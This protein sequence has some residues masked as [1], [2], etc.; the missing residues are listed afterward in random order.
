MPIKQ[1]SVEELKAKM[2][3]GEKF[4]LVD[5]RGH[6]EYE[7]AQ[8]KGS[9]LIPLQEFPARAPDELSADDEIVIHCHHGGRSQRACQFLADMGYKNLSNLAGGIDAWSVKIDPQV[10]R[11]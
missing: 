7:T 9:V 5:V 2:D 11:Y 3:R 8:I 10:K 4:K 1:I 6:D